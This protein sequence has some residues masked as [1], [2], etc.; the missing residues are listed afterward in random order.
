MQLVCIYP[1]LY[2][3]G[4]RV[5]IANLWK[6][7]AVSLCGAFSWNVL[8]SDFDVMSMII[9]ALSLVSLVGMCGFAFKV[10]IGRAFVWKVNFGFF[11]LMGSAF[12]VLSAFGLAR[13]FHFDLAFSLGAVVALQIPLVYAL[14][15][16]AYRSEEVWQRNV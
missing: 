5:V 13:N 12:L 16:Y 7:Y 3:I 1:Q 10:A 4:V 14:W 2:V 6:V 15:A 8:R 11:A 9:N